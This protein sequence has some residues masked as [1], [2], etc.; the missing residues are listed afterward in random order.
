MEMIV[1]AQQP[2][3]PPTNS[4][5]LLAESLSNL[6]TADLATSSTSSFKTI[7]NNLSDSSTC[8]SE[9][10]NTSINSSKQ[11]DMMMKDDCADLNQILN[12]TLELTKLLAIKGA[13]MDA[14]AGQS[15]PVALAEA[16]VDEDD[17]VVGTGEVTAVIGQQDQSANAAETPPVVSTEEE[18]EEESG[19]V[20][21]EK[22]INEIN[23]R[24]SACVVS[25]SAPLSLHQPKATVVLS[26]EERISN[27]A[28]EY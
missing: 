16:E 10:L 28:K 15:G 1:S 4:S 21:I 7:D 18:E 22:I 3:P 8:S 14:A 2:P 23:K 6:D 20:R 19:P 11:M 24:N 17:N 12:E 13:E 9:L 26:P 5:S 25:A 27:E